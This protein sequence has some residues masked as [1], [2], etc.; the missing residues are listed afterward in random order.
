MRGRRVGC[1][2]PVTKLANRSSIIMDECL[3]F[4]TTVHYNGGLFTPWT[5]RPVAK[6]SSTLHR[7]LDAMLGTVA[8]VRVLR[9][10]TEHG[11]ALAATAIATRARVARQSAW[12]AVARLSELGIIETF[13]EPHGT[14][15]RLNAAHPFVA[16]LQALFQSEAQRVERLFETVRAAAKAMKPAPIAIWLYGSVARGEDK[17]GSDIDLAILSPADHPS[18]QE[19][20]LTDALY[21]F[22]GELTSRMSIIGMTRADVRRMKRGGDRIWKEI[23]RDAVPIVGPAPTEALREQRRTKKGPSR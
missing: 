13:G 21:P 20:A 7:P 14:L 4:W 17:P 15:F 3:E 8:N 11:G 23:E 1:R 22:M 2:R 12:N 9:A 18:A 6:R 5:M 16:S 19:M 10:L